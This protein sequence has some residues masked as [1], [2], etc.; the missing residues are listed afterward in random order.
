[1]PVTYEVLD[2]VSGSFAQFLL[3]IIVFYSGE[4]VWKE[5]SV[6]VNLM[7]DALPVPNWVVFGG[8]LLALLGV[9]LLLSG[10]MM[11]C[12]I[13]IQTFQGYFRYELGLYVQTL[14]FYDLLPF[15]TFTA[16]SFFVQVMLNNKFLGFFVVVLF[17]FF[18]SLFLNFLGIE[19]NLFRFNGNSGLVYSDMNGFG[20]YLPGYLSFFGYWGAFS[21]ILLLISSL[22]WV[23]GSDLSRK[24]RGRN[25]RQNFGPIP[26]M[27][28]AVL[29]L[30]FVSLGS[31]IYYNTHVLNPFYTSKQ[32]QKLQA[33]YEKKYKKYAQIPQPKVSG[34]KL[35]VDLF[36]ESRK[37]RAKGTYTLQNKT[38]QDIKEIHLLLFNRPQKY[39]FSF[40]VPT[41]ALKADEKFDF[42]VYTLKKPLKPGQ[43][44]RLN[45]EL[46]YSNEG[47]RNRGSNTDL[48]H[49]G[50]FFNNF[51]YFPLIGYQ[52]AAELGLDEIRQK[53]GLPPRPRTPAI[54][55]P[56][57]QQE[58]FINQHSD[59]ITF[60]ATLSTAP[61]QIAIA[62]GY[63]QKEWRKNGRRY[64]QYKMDAPILNFYSILSGRF[65]LKKD[66]WKGP[67]GDT[68]RLEIFHHP[69]H[70][71][72]L[73]RM[74]KGMKKA[75]D[76]Y[77]THF[78]PYQHRQARIIE[79]P[80]YAGFAQSFPN[81]IPYSESLG[82]IANVRKKDD[83][84]YVFYL[85]AHEIAHQWW[86]HQIVPANTQGAGTISESMS[87][88]GALMVM[89]KEYGPDQMKKFLRLELDRYLRG[90]GSEI[91]EEKPLLLSENQ[92]YI[93]YQ[94]GSVVMYALKDLLG[95]E[96]LNRAIRAYVQDY[97]FKGPPYTTMKDLLGYLRRETPDSL[98]YLLR[99]M[100][101]TITLYDLEVK[102]VTYRPIG[103]EYEVEIT[104]SAQKLRAD[105]TGKESKIKMQDYVDV[106]IFG[107]KKVK[108]K[109]ETVAI[110]FK[111]H[112]LRSQD[113]SLRIRVAQKP[114]RAGLDPYHKLI[115][116]K[117]D[118]NLRPALLKDTSPKAKSAQIAPPRAA[119]LA[120]M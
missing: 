71:Y 43:Q 29:L 16:L 70:T 7:F 9:L 106:G 95:E 28:L 56:K 55:D 60:E 34:V 90:R 58:N 61:D 6:R 94:K 12:G 51:A 68:V 72:N 15:L 85:T 112:R 27:V 77:S 78:G 114:N 20:H 54:D 69:V 40:S 107:E 67:Q 63:L 111:K 82:F 3:A 31:F 8:K 79:F 59:F 37:M 47:F 113:R 87:Q 103:K 48:V 26:R 80:R 39:K 21:G 102:S 104:F 84:D 19:D 53:Q 10:V 1:M 120:W 41:Q 49:N 93:H 73:D 38:Q 11:V 91:K 2:L 17:F 96:R 119:F 76:Y 44:L 23:R 32:F 35:E 99:D 22:Y 97:R 118:D 86:G 75:L 30:L 116:R 98:R 64:F 108:G 25:A 81:T 52:E 109:T 66:L 36:P 33:D 65:A 46:A 89:E 14:F 5:R 24:A 110:Y 115:D 100:I 105:G 117:P 74:M 45:F 62:P 18:N 13:M 4:V 92:Q 42:Y 88:Y 101:E 50:T 83:I 57:A